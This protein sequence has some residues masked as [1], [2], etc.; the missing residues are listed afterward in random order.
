MNCFCKVFT[1][2]RGVSN[3]TNQGLESKACSRAK[4]GKL[5]IGLVTCG[6]GFA[7]DWSK[8]CRVGSDWLHLRPNKRAWKDVFIFDN[9]WKV[10]CQAIVH[11]CSKCL[12]SLLW[13]CRFLRRTLATLWA[14]AWL[15]LRSCLTLDRSCP[16]TET[17]WWRKH[18][19]RR[20]LF[21]SNGSVCNVKIFR[22]L[23]FDH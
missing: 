12:A 4:R 15:P 7:C 22:L 3:G 1:S 19:W 9:F 11:L 23:R 13:V 2:W 10:S 6:F 8:T 14:T 5:N 16:T 17:S 18:G 21:S 20:Y